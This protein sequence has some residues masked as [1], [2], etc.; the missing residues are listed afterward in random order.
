MQQPLRMGSRASS[1][2]GQ[3]NVVPQMTVIDQGDLCSTLQFEDDQIN[4]QRH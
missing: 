1:L 4:H 3:F 2:T